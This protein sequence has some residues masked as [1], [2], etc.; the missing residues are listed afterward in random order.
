[1][2]SILD[3]TRNLEGFLH[4]RFD[5]ATVI[6]A[7]HFQKKI[8]TDVCRACRRVEWREGF[9]IVGQQGEP[10]ALACEFDGGGKL[11]LFNRHGISQI[12]ETAR[13]EP[14][15]L[16]QCGDGERGGVCRRL[17]PRDLDAL[18]RLDVR[19]QTRAHTLHTLRHALCVSA[20]AR[21]VE[22][23]RGRRQF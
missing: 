9:E 21:H 23:E 20:H 6:A 8:E 15:G 19:A 12:A 5:A 1:M 13:G 10:F 14:T 18:M 22:H 17:Q 16:G 3:A 4:V 11:S 2:R 7:I